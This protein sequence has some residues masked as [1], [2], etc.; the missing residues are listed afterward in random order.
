MGLGCR[1]G[2]ACHPHARLCTHIWSLNQCFRAVVNVP[3]DTMVSLI[4]FPRFVIM[5]IT[6]VVNP[7][8]S[9][10][11]RLPRLSNRSGPFRTWRLFRS[12]ALCALWACEI[13]V[14]SLASSVCGIGFSWICSP[15][16]QEMQNG[17]TTRLQLC[18]TLLCLRNW[19]VMFSASNVSKLSTSSVSKAFSVASS[20][21]LMRCADCTS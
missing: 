15:D 3:P 21:I 5:S 7:C 2:L 10:P 9:R 12:H 8:T 14:R 6:A 4:I 11:R 16:P 13:A 19:Y 18:Y 20:V 1:S 17:K